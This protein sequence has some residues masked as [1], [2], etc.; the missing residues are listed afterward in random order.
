[1]Q[2]RLLTNLE[3]H[4]KKLLQIV[5]LGQPE[6]QEMFRQPE[7]RQLSQ[8][9]TARFHLNAMEPE[10]VGPYV[11]HRLAVAGAVDPRGIFP[12][13]TIARLHQISKGIPRVINLVCDRALLGAYSRDT[14]V[15]DIAILNTAA[16][17]VLGTKQWH[18][19]P[20]NHT[21]NWMTGAAA[22]VV[23]LALG[24]AGSWLWLS[25][26][27]TAD[28]NVPVSA[29]SLEALPAPASTTLA[30]PPP[31]IAETAAA[32]SLPELAA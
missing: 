12:A 5:L 6:L 14:R 18:I 32:A 19:A 20:S 9:V 29:A 31:S 26:A 17:E 24:A 10:E 22:A 4:E 8:R 27:R 28:A 25:A 13:K 11:Y 30:V 1:E 2:L 16:N 21:R 3:T 23:L 15:V 7:L